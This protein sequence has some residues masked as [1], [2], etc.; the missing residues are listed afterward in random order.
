MQTAHVQSAF[1]IY[2]IYIRVCVAIGKVR[3]EGE[4]L[5]NFQI[6]VSRF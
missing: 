5:W 4:N 6:P 3:T 2:L 1:F